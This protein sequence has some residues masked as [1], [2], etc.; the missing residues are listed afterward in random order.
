[1]STYL[2]KRIIK[3]FAYPNDYEHYVL[4]IVALCNRDLINHLQFA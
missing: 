1:M 3:A 2:P 4:K